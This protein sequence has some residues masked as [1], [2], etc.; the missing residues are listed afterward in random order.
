[1]S[2]DNSRQLLGSCETSSKKVEE[3]QQRGCEER[4]RCKKKT[5]KKDATVA[6]VKAITVLKKR[7]RPIY[8]YKH[9]HIHSFALDIY[10]GFLQKVSTPR[11]C[12][13]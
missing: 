12:L 4:V 3:L 1:M 8:V 9:I 10:K 13:I 2:D 11:R 5:S 6:R 7:R